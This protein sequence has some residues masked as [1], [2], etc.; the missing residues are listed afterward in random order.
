MI[1]K[2]TDIALVQLSGPGCSYVRAAG[3]M[4]QYVGVGPGDSQGI[5]RRGA[6]RQV[7]SIITSEFGAVSSIAQSSCK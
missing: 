7:L 1:E 6:C 2:R 4:D 3:T 5:E